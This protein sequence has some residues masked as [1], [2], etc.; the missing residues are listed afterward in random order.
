[1]HTI[2]PLS[3]IRIIVNVLFV[4]TL[5]LSASSC[6]GM[7]ILL[8]RLA[9]R[10]TTTYNAVHKPLVPT[11]LFLMPSLYYLITWHIF[12]DPKLY[13]PNAHT[14]SKEVTEYVRSHLQRF[15]V[16]QADQIHVFWQ[17]DAQLFSAVCNKGLLMGEQEQ[18]YI[19]RLQS[20]R[21]IFHRLFN[22]Q[23]SPYFIKG[24]LAHEANHLKQNDGL[25]Q[26]QETAL[27]ATGTFPLYMGAY[28]LLSQNLA[29]RLK[30]SW[31]AGIAINV[32]HNIILKARARERERL[33]DESIPDDPRVLHELYYFFMMSDQ[34]DN[35]WLQQLFSTHPSPAERAQR[36][37][38]RLKALSAND[39]VTAQ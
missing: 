34:C 4:A 9:S 21:P 12:K 24:A 28:T 31:L 6:Y 20:P 38:E 10:V 29:L 22:I 16:P 30:R 33:A 14:A 15:G 23:P 26:M 2:S 17:K 1:M 32:T 18:E 19:Q 37:R 13:F 27:L 7:S 3:I 25:T 35:T 8:K 5:L 36:F 11:T 39:A